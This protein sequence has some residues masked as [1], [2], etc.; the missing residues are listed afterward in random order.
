MHEDPV[1][2]EVRK[3]RS[4]HAAKYGYDLVQLDVALA[5]EQIAVRLDDRGAKAPCEKGA[6]PTVG[7][8]DVLHLA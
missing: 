3:H 4:E 8:V 1:V 6:G 7:P 2:A 5:G